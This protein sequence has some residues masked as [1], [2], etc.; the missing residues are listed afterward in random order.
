[1]TAPRFLKRLFI[2]CAAVGILG[3]GF[4]FFTGWRLLLTERRSTPGQAL[5]VEGFG[6]LGVM[7]EPKLV[8]KFFNGRRVLTR[9]YHFSPNGILGRDACPVWLGPDE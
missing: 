4:L 9:V 7:I 6:D 2:G 1:V 3:E 8:C 5:V